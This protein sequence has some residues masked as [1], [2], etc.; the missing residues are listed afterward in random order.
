LMA[1]PHGF[2]L[3]APADVQQKDIASDVRVSRTR[4]IP[5]LGF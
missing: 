1:E 5:Q 2:A 4:F 3:S